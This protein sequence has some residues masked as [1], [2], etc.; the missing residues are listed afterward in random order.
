VWGCGG[1]PLTPGPQGLGW[2]YSA[3]PSCRSIPGKLLRRTQRKEP[4]PRMPRADRAG[5]ALRVLCVGTGLLVFGEVGEMRWTHTPPTKGERTGGTVEELLVVC[6]REWPP[7]W[8][9]SRWGRTYVGQHSGGRQLPGSVLWAYAMLS[10]SGSAVD[11]SGWDCPF[12]RCSLCSLCPCFL[13][14]ASRYSYDTMMATLSPPKAFPACLKHCFSL[15]L[16]S[17]TII[18]SGH[19]NGI[20]DVVLLV[21]RLL[22]WSPQLDAQR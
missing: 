5:A 20:V 9:E 1:S 6:Q 19:S 4:G 8:T 22:L 14:G 18:S 12:S 21:L 11:P 13:V 10:H 16:P 7:G 15:V 3:S 17:R 2:H